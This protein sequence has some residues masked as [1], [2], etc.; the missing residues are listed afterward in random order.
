MNPACEYANSTAGHSTLV[1]I[2]L[3]GRGTYGLYEAAGGI[4]PT[5]LDACGGHYGP[6]PAVTYDGVTYAAASNVYHYHWTAFVR[7][8]G[9]SVGSIALLNRRHVELTLCCRCDPTHAV[10]PPYRCVYHLCFAHP[11]AHSVFSVHSAGCYGPAPSVSAAKALYTG[12]GDSGTKYSGCSSRGN[13]TNYPLFCPS[14]LAS[15]G[16][17]G[18]WGLHTAPRCA[19]Y[20]NTTGMLADYF[21]PSAACPDTEA[22]AAVT[23][24][25]T[26]SQATTPS[27]SA[28]QAATVTQT[29]S[30]GASPSQAGTSSPSSA[31]TASPSQAMTGSISPTASVTRALG[32]T[33]SSSSSSSIGPSAGV[34]AGATIGA[35]VGAALLV[36]LIVLVVLRAGG[37]KKAVVDKAPSAPPGDPQPPSYAS[38][39]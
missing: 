10:Q 30:V 1:S 6:V 3:D 4:V 23:P 35:V 21:V 25:V 29:L 31:V 11:R 9:R 2:M 12:C 28:S 22:I 34:I 32:D 27:R 17:G 18:P 19:V 37:S 20:E 8:E 16:K 24:T 14:T 38:S 5:D 39:V 15:S 7:R 33:S 26:P 13:V 36:A